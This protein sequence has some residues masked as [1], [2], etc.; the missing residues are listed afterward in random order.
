MAETFNCPSCGAPL[1]TDGKETSIHCEYCGETVIVPQN[2]RTAN[3][4][5]PGPVQIP[6]QPDQPVQPGNFRGRMD[7]SQLR[8]MMMAIR[9]GQ[10]EEAARFFQ[11]GTGADEAQSRQT[12]EMIA[13]QISGTNRILPAELAALMMGAMAQ[14]ARNYSQPLQPTAPVRPRPRRS[15]LGC[16]ILLIGIVVVLYFA[17]TAISPTQLLKSLLSGNK[18]DLVRQTALA[19]I[20]QVQTAIATEVGSV[21][22]GGTQIGGSAAPIL[23]FGG[24]GI[25]QGLLKDAR[26]IAI[27]GQGRIYTAEY[28]GGK[29][30]VFDS[31]GKFLAQWMVDAKLPLLSLAVSPQGTVYIVQGGKIQAYDGMTGKS[32]GAINVPKAVGFSSVI[33]TSTGKLAATSSG[34]DDILL[35]DNQGTVALT[36]PNAISSQSGDSES[37]MHL[38]VDGLGNI[39]A[40]GTV[41]NAVFKFSPEGKFLN[42]FGSQGQAAGQFQAVE[43]IA[44][45]GQGQ[46]YV[47]DIKGIQVFSSDGRYLKT[48]KLP[49]GVPFGMAFNQ[50]GDLVV[51]S[52]VNV[53]EFVVN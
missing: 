4:S 53:Y 51:T 7:P 36:I 52:R 22:S 37:I 29:V 30:Q 46:V 25:G 31:Q 18:N 47:S 50:K 5:A 26:S 34:S 2:L 20:S 13:N 10:L 41:N 28:T 19:P 40:L 14:S 38:A 27:D 3:T 15:N 43:N 35:F 24:E 44:V 48:I 17:Y 8:Q 9:A 21:F 42:R 23:T 11:Q 49:D 33:A 16:L 6:T 1:E 39:Y 45:D 12:V 32:L